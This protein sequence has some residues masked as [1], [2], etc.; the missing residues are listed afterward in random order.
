[1]SL[2]TM[3]ARSQTSHPRYLVGGIPRPRRPLRA[4]RYRVSAPNSTNTSIRR[5]QGSATPW[6]GAAIAGS[7]VDMLICS[8]SLRDGREIFRSDLDV[9]TL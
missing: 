1:M 2:L 6:R 4:W 8:V 5:P 3:A 7:P 9:L